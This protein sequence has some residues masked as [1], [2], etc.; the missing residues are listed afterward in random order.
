M[1]V[2]KAIDNVLEAVNRS[3]PGRGAI[4]I[5]GPVIHNQQVVE[6]LEQKGVR[7]LSDSLSENDTVII[8]AHGVPPEREQ[9]F[10]Q[11]GCTVINSTCPLVARIQHIITEEKDRGRTILIIGDKGHPEVI[12]LMGYAGNQGILIE[13]P[14]DL[15]TIDD[16][17]DIAV[18]AQSTQDIESFSAIVHKV[19][20]RFPDASV[21]DTICRATKQRQ[22]SVKQLAEACDAVIVVG[23]KNSG[24]TKRLAEIASRTVPT[25]HVET[26]DELDEERISE[27]HTVGIAGGA[28]TPNW[29]IINVKE[30]L[31]RISE[32]T[33]TFPVRLGKKVYR[34][35][36]Y[37][38]LMA[39]CAGASL[40]AAYIHIHGFPHIFMYSLITLL[41]VFSM[42]TFNRFIKFSADQFNAPDRAFFFRRTKVLFLGTG[43]L[44][45]AAAAG[46][47]LTMGIRPFLILAACSVPGIIYPVNILPRSMENIFRYRSF[48][49][50]PGSKDIVIGLGWAVV[51]VL[52]PSLGTDEYFTQGTFPFFL[53]VFLLVFTRSVLFDILDIP[54]DRITG[55]DTLPILLGFRNTRYVLAALLGVTSLL[56][57][58]GTAAGFLPVRSLIFFVPVVYLAATTA[59]CTEKAAYYP[60]LYG[61]IID[62][63]F[64]ITAAAVLAFI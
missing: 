24:N 40:S 11:T 5:D 16:S 63:S 57:A 28:S 14:D 45:L 62:F 1:G 19:R 8:R 41:Y 64:I 42:H 55:N 15:N 26:S 48:R 23:G 21:H 36:I 53:L 44:S 6:L 7:V 50:M 46:I 58:G 31:S 35:L 3:K 25:F 17:A 29:I 4:Y 47:S 54:G 30:H 52:L 60:A 20:E 61:G 39:A 43:V 59:G 22:E 9:Q 37:S 13:K 49:D 38:H 33:G 34:F 18:V 12:G 51:I 56:L 10:R 2:K 32:K 27:F